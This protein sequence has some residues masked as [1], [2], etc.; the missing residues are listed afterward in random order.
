MNINDFKTFTKSLKIPLSAGTTSLPTP[1]CLLHLNS[2][3]TQ[4][5]G[6]RQL[7]ILENHKY[8]KL[9]AL[10]PVFGIR[11]LMVEFPWIGL[12]CFVL[13]SGFRNSV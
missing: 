1:V 2:D 7:Q 11:V 9:F 10:C 12:G 4:R 5:F 3:F 13:P 6:K 8:S